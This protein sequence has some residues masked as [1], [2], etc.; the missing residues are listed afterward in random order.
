MKYE[1]ETS[2]FHSTRRAFLLSAGIVAAGLSMASGA[3]AEPLPDQAS[4]LAVRITSYGKFQDAAWDHLPR[5]GVHHLFLPVPK[6]EEADGMMQKLEKHGLKALVIRGDADWSKDECVER[7][8]GQLAICEKM[9]VHY[10]FLSVKCNGA[11]KEAVYGRLRKA[12]DVAKQHGVT[13]TFETHPE[14]GTNGDVQLETMAAVN[15]PNVRINFD[16]GNISYYNKGGDVVAELKKVVTKVGTM[17]LKDHNLEPESWNFPVLGKGK[18]NFPEI[19]K[20]LREN[21]FMGPVTIEFEGVKG[22]ELD[23]AQTKQSIADSVA[24]LKSLALFK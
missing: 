5:I 20:I 7:L 16:T 21:G 1:V 12:G 10:M 23:E 22:V 8:A 2:E 19:L 9:G 14:L 4:P 17:E 3:N 6:P 11:P 18:V 13:L 15:H 24:Y